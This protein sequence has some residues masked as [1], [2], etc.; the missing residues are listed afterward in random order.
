MLV[1]DSFTQEKS[2][3]ELQ[4]SAKDLQT[5]MSKKQKQVDDH[6]A[7]IAQ[8]QDEYAKL[9]DRISTLESQQLGV[10][11]SDDKKEKGR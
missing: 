5:V 2:R 7:A 11:M 9:T 3:K 10:G 8:S 4:K 1:S 6:K